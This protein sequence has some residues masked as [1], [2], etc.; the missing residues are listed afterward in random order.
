MGGEGRLAPEAR[1][2]EEAPLLALMGAPPEPAVALPTMTLG[3]HVVED[4]RTAGLSLKAHP[5]AFFR[6][7]LNE[8]GA[9]HGVGPEVDEGRARALSVGGLV[10]I[11]QRPGTAKGVVFIT[12][13]DE[14]GPANAVVWARRLR[15]QPP[16]GDERQLPGRPRPAAAGGRGHPHGRRT[17]HRSLGTAGGAEAAGLAQGRRLGPA[18]SASAAGTSTEPLRAI[19]RGGPSRRSPCPPAT[20]RSSRAAGL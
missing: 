4:Y 20:R 2:A 1:V 3:A 18:A 14:T 6:R 5:C 15:R 17:L 9:V 12:L 8:M 10:L 11:R 19:G 16:H 13:E 7:S